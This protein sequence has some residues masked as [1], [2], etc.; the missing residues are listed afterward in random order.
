[1]ALYQTLYMP[2][3]PV[4]DLYMTGQPVPDFIHART[5]HCFLLNVTVICEQMD[6]R[7]GIHVAVLKQSGPSEE[8]NRAS[9]QNT[10]FM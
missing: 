1:M 5:A 6:V 7:G 3:Q 4:P 9:F 8:G 2:G 10:F